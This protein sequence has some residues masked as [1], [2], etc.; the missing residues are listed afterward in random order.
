MHKIQKH[1]GQVFGVKELKHNKDATWVRESK[2]D[3]WEEQTR[4]STDL[5]G[6]AGEDI[7][8]DSKLKGP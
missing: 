8:E 4:T 7:E 3:K 1:F 6:E 5:A 2:K